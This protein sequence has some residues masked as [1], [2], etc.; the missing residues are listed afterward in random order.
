MRTLF[1]KV[2]PSKPKEIPLDDTDSRGFELADSLEDGQSLELVVDFYKPLT[3]GGLYIVRRTPN[4]NDWTLVDHGSMEFLMRASVD[5][6]IESRKFER[7]LD[8]KVLSAQDTPARMRVAVYLSASVKEGQENPTVVMMSD[9]SRMNWKAYK[10]MCDSCR[11]K[12]RRSSFTEGS[13]CSSSPSGSVSPRQNVGGACSFTC[14][15]HAADFGDIS[16][17]VPSGQGILRMTH[18]L[19]QIHGS[20]FTKI[21]VSVPSLGRDWCPISHPLLAERT[22]TPDLDM[23]SRLPVWSEKLQALALEF[24]QREVLPSRRNYQLV[25]SSPSHE[26]KELVCMHYRTG[27]N[28]Y[29]LEM[30]PGNEERMS[31]IQAFCVAVSSSLWQ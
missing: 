19:M 3:A 27:K 30:F 8:F 31:L 9:R 22:N 18:V 24:R 25:V 29:T 4:T 26:N 11:Y 6:E 14:P 1:K 5:L 10:V 15:S 2:L 28:E 12:R 23:E 7:D 20:A 16:G 13:D 17:V 21:K